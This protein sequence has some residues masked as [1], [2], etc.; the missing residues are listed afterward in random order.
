MIETAFWELGGGRRSVDVVLSKTKLVS[1]M[2]EV[3]CQPTF[4]DGLAFIQR[5]GSFVASCLITEA[6]ATSPFEELMRWQAD[7]DERSREKNVSYES[8]SGYRVLQY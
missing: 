6:A 8:A 2:V 1:V 3:V 7:K 4:V 5:S